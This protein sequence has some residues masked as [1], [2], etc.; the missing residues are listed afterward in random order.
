MSK[1][2]TQKG[3]ALAAGVALVATGLSAPANAAGLADKSFVSLLPNQTA[4]QGVEYS[5]LLDSYIE[6]K[7]NPTSSIAAAGNLKFLVEDTAS[8]TK[9]DASADGTAGTTNGT[10][11]TTVTSIGVALPALAG[12]TLAAADGDNTLTITYASHGLAANDTIV[13]TATSAGAGETVDTSGTYVVAT[14]PDGNTFTVEAN[15]ATTGA[16]VDVTTA[17]ALYKVVTAAG[18]IK[19]VATPVSTTSTTFYEANSF[20]VGNILD[21]VTFTDAAH[22]AADLVVTAATATSFTVTHGARTVTHRVDS[23]DTNGFSRPVSVKFENRTV[24]ENSP[25]GEAWLLPTNVAVQTPTG[26]NGTDGRKSALDG[27]YVVDTGVASS[28]NDKVLRLINTGAATASVNVTAW[29]D[30]NSNGLIDDTEYTSETRTVTFTKVSDASFATSLTAPAF[31]GAGV[32]AF[33]DLGAAFNHYQIAKSDQDNLLS[34]RFQLNAAADQSSNATFDTATGLL[35]ATSSAGSFA[36]PIGV[37]VYN[38]QARYDST[39]VGTAAYQTVVAG[40]VN[41]DAL[42]ALDADYTANYNGTNV[43]TGTTALSLSTQVTETTGSV[44]ARPGLPAKVTITKN[45]LGVSTVISAGGKTLTYA[46]TSITYDTVTNADGEVVVDVASSTGTKADSITV[47]VEVLDTTTWQSATKTLVWADA[48]IASASALIYTDGV[49]SAVRN[50]AKGGAVTLNYMVEDTFG[51]PFVA[52]G[53][54]I[55]FATTGSVVGAGSVSGTAPVVNGLASFTLTDNTVATTGNYTVRATLQ[56]INLAGTAYDSL[57]HIADTTVYV[58]TA[59]AA[60]VT[61]STAMLATVAEGSRKLLQTVDMK[62]GDGRQ[63]AITWPY[64]NVTGANTDSFTVAGRVSASTG[65]PVQGQAVVIS[66]PGAGIATAHNSATAVHGVGSLT[67]YT[68]ASGDYSVELYSN[69][70]GKVDITVTAGAAS[71]TT[72]AYFKQAANTAGTTWDLTGVSSYV[73]PGYSFSL[74]AV[75]SDKYGNAIESAAGKV[76][77]AWDGPIF[78]V[79][80]TLPTAT[81]AFGEIKFGVVPSSNE[82]GSFSYT[83]Q[84]AGLDGAF[85]TADDVTGSKTVIIG[86]ADVASWTSN[87][88]DGTVKMYAKNIVGAGKV[89]FMVNGEEIAWI[90]ATT[91]ADPKLR[92]AGAQGAAYLVRTIDLVEG[93]KNVLEIYVDGVRT[94]RTAYTY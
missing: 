10:S 12:A 59:A 88:N 78:T 6:L 28:T 83:V 71:K 2:M 79:P 46:G 22:N 38:A 81:D 82:V 85:D 19:K 57:S 60:T 63:I 24:F 25:L 33:V 40:A 68:D 21:G 3:L 30:A 36:S 77:L 27:T 94:T 1:N 9:F 44:D 55:S 16:T 18:A 65:A 62:A 35:T 73:T 52:A 80:T 41:I 72:V 54:R 56:K 15:G 5:V 70:E 64:S 31:G 14:V 7:A 4:A 48:A 43:K 89:Q 13:L 20:D 58:G 17:S 39:S 50:V 29:V 69:K 75:L 53:Y 32:E 26:W 61:T 92:L 74:A 93:Q 34:V 8:I 90:R 86:S 67:V 66:A 23:D 45:A 51:A 47:K 87:Q 11:A 76:K 49:G 37:G 42:G 84:Y 91:F